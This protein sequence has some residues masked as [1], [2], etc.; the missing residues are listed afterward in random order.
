MTL[1]GVIGVLRMLI[2]YCIINYSIINYSITKGNCGYKRE[3]EPDVESMGER[4]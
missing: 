2:S 4:I 3:Y 1:V